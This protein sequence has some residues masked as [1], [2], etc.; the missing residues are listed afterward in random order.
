MFPALF[1]ARYW[2][3][4]EPSPGS[5]PAWLGWM[6]FF[7]VVAG[8]GTISAIIYVAMFG[9][10]EALVAERELQ[11]ASTAEDAANYRTTT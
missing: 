2:G 11:E 9:R 7:V 10:E 5:W 3:L 6:S 4:P 1:W 8:I